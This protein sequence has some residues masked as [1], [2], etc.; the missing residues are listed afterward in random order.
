[1]F[2]LANVY[3]CTEESIVYDDIKENKFFKY[4][5]FV[6]DTKNINK[7]LPTLFIGYKNTKELFNKNFDINNNKI[8]IKNYY[9]FSFEESKK[10]FHKQFLEFL[11]K[12]EEF[13]FVDKKYSIIDTIFTKNVN[14]EDNLISYLNQLSIDMVF[15]SKNLLY[16]YDIEKDITHGLDLLFFNYLGY[17]VNNIKKC[18][19]EKNIKYI[20]D[21][22]KKINHFFINLFPMFDETI[23][24]HIPF[25]MSLKVG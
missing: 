22:N 18:L 19:I 7:K 23:D 14:S 3:N 21:E 16:L 17:N 20:T 25:L 24:R 5:N 13:I 15:E 2:Y 9:C 6:S 4:L 10:L 1:M 12:L 11:N 8:N